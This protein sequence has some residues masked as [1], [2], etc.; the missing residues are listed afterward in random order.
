MPFEWLPAQAQG[1]EGRVKGRGRGKELV[2]PGLPGVPS[3]PG[4]TATLPML[5][6][7]GG[8][9][10]FTRQLPGAWGAGSGVGE[11]MRKHVA[12]ARGTR[13]NHPRSLPA[14]QSPQTTSGEATGGRGGARGEPAS[15]RRRPDFRVLPPPAP[16][17]LPEAPPTRP[18]PRS[19]CAGHG[20]GMAGA[21]LRAALEQR[22]GA[23][24]IRT[25]VVEHP[26][27]R[28]CCWRGGLRCG[29]LGR[30]RNVPQRRGVQHSPR[31][32]EPSRDPT[33]HR[34]PFG[35]VTLLRENWT[36]SSWSDLV[37]FRLDAL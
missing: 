3:S 4:P 16:L 21:D 33:E 30:G 32:P 37:P 5:N 11:A 2:C 24:A 29:G 34:R 10:R 17:G 14:G 36:F 6:P 13:A 26:E 19:V 1:A 23:L 20:G 27:V 9:D 31:A 35:T 22:L 18:L 28:R 25:E 8:P 7:S 15:G 12:S